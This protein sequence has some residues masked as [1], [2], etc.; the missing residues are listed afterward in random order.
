[1]LG[2]PE[3]VPFF[4]PTMGEDFLLESTSGGF[5]D[6]KCLPGPTQWL[7]A[8]PDFEPLDYQQ[9]HHELEVGFVD[10]DTSALHFAGAVYPLQNYF[11][12]FVSFS[13]LSYRSKDISRSLNN[14]AKETRF[15]K[16][17]H[18]PIP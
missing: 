10:L 17:P 1:M 14:N 9:S 3:F 15:K 11:L 7:N 12:V 16:I 6:V 2:A 13:A 8:A 18:S 4:L 5:A